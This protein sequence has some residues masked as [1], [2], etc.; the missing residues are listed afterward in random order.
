M[1]MLGERIRARRVELGMTQEEL[2][3]RLFMSSRSVRRW[4]QGVMRP[5]RANRR[6]LSK[7]LRVRDGYWKSGED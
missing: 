2:A 4:E 1:V 3:D 6:A 7:A 5:T